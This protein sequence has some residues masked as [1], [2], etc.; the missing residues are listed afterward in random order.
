MRDLKYAVRSLR[1]QPSF[2]CAAIAI[3]VMGIGATTAV[4]SVLRGVL[5]RPLPYRAPEQL[6]LLRAQL[7]GSGPTPLLTSLEFAALRAQ[8]DV[9][10][11]VAAIVHSAGNLTAPEQMAPMSAAAASENFF[12]TL[13]VAP[14]L[15]R[16]V[17]RG[18]GGRSINISYEVWQRHF[19]GETGVVGR[20]IDVDN[21]PVSVAGVL[22]RGF[23]LYLASDIVL[24]PQ[25]DLVY[26]RSSGYDDDPFR[27][28]VVVARLGRG[29]AIETARAA[30]DTLARRVVA[31]HPD[32]YRTGPVRLSVAPVDA[33]VKSTAK[34]AL[35]R[36]PW[37][38]RRYC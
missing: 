13:G 9:F 3:M 12:D 19:A 2:A 7:P 21:S 30:I 11:S 6:V 4:Y 24:S 18:D 1:R 25:L 31:E 26:Y 10:E 15:G 33:E 28:N 29:V 17:R 38:W 36:R 27:G 23:K 14:V 8:T 20:T 16:F 37:R 35:I 22:P 5:I 32:R 34:P